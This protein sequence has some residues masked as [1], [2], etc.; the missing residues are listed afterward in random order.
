MGRGV[1]C[2]T[3]DPEVPDSNTGG[4]R[5]ITLTG[6]IRTIPPPIPLNHSD[7]CEIVR[8]EKQI[9]CSTVEECRTRDP[10][11]NSSNPV[12]AKETLGQV[13]SENSTSNPSV[14][15]VNTLIDRGEKQKSLWHSGRVQNYISWRSPVQRGEVQR[16]KLSQVLSEQYHCQ[17]L[18]N[19]VKYPKLSEVKHRFDCLRVGESRT[20]D[21]EVNSSN[22]GMAK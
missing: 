16:E 11:V 13:Q 14:P 15:E 7:I 20:T 17:S 5:R 19:R 1:E 4:Q 21:S 3:E 6:P 18:C 12:T 2:R 8:G 9:S 10:E 22:P